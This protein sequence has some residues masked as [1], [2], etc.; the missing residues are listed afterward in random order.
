[1]RALPY[2]WL[3]VPLALALCAWWFGEQV[4]NEKPGSRDECGVMM[5]SLGCYVA[6]LASVLSGFLALVLR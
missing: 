5:A 4:R 2:L 1:M 6:A 3:L